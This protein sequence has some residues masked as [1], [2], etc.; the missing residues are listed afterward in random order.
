MFGTKIKGIS[1]VLLVVGL[2][3]AGAVGLFYLYR[4]QGVLRAA[5]AADRA[6]EL[7][8]QPQ[9]ADQPKAKG[10]PPA[11]KGDNPDEE[12]LRVLIDNVLKA[13]GGEDKLNKLR[14]TMT[15]KHNNGETQQYF[16]QPSKGFR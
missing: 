8:H 2:A 11:K 15:V 10:E 1:A 5:A 12:K 13:H 7:L 9:A 4:S 16:V 6:A 3:L 14:F